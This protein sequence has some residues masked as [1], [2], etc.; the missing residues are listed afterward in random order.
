MNYII[1]PEIFTNSN[2]FIN[3][4]SPSLYHF[5]LGCHNR[6]IIDTID[7]N[8]SSKIQQKMLPKCKDIIAAK[9]KKYKFRFKKEK[10]FFPAVEN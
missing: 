10:I 2:E 3:L 6:I 8:I 7:F 4:A 5:L 1:R 9:E